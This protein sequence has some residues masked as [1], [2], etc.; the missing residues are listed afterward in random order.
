MHG[1]GPD[2]DRAPRAQC[3][4]RHVDDGRGQCHAPTAKS[5]GLY[6]HE[7]EAHSAC[8]FGLRGAGGG[9]RSGKGALV[10]GQSQEAGLKTLMMTHPLRRDAA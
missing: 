1:P 7:R 9:G 5:R 10:T 3:T 8:S 2:R 4:Q 6:C